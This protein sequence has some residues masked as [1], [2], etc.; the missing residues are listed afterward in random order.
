M[1][2][3]DV[4]GSDGSRGPGPSHMYYGT[5]LLIAVLLCAWFVFAHWDSVP[6]LISSTRAALP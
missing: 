3:S 1:N 6:Q 2:R 5:V 4:G